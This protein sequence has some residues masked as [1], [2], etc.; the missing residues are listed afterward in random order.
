MKPK[1]S[2]SPPSERA[3][4]KDEQRAPFVHV[5]ALPSE[6]GGEAMVLTIDRVSVSISTDTAEQI[7]AAL[8]L[9][10]MGREQARLRGKAPHSP[11][12]RG[13]SLDS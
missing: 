11:G 13:G 12:S 1:R 6:E 5:C 9:S 7:L 8:M 3:S 2:V 10:L 4:K